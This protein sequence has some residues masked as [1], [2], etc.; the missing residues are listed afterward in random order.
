MHRVDAM[1]RILELLALRRSTPVDADAVCANL[2]RLIDLSR[3]GL[4]SCRLCPGVEF[5]YH[6]V[7]PRAPKWVMSKTGVLGI[8]DFSGR[9]VLREIIDFCSPGEVQRIFWSVWLSAYSFCRITLE[10]R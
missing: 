3:G 5:H 7:G 2:P 9:V 8:G 6:V 1:M 4:H 10:A